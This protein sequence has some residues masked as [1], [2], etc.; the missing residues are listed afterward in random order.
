MFSRHLA[1][2]I[3]CNS[4]RVAFVF[5]TETW[6]HLS[7][8][9]RT[10][11]VARENRAKDRSKRKGPTNENFAHVWSFVDVWKAAVSKTWYVTLF[12]ERNRSLHSVQK[13]KK[14]SKRVIA[15]YTLTA[16]FRTMEPMNYYD[17]FRPCNFFFVNYLND[18]DVD[19]R[20]F[21]QLR[22]SFITT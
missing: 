10:C 8:F 21:T 12:Y 6:N 15:L 9:L 20:M 4:V 17:M 16:C 19:P 18:N 7:F 5:A 1:I 14:L 2:L 3:P 11:R 13:F 22:Y